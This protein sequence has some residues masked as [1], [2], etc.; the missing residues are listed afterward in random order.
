[1]G[2]NFT[3]IKKEKLKNLE[4]TFD[5]MSNYCRKQ[6]FQYINFLAN[7]DGRFQFLTYFLPRKDAIQAFFKEGSWDKGP[8]WAVFCDYLT[9][10]VIITIKD[11]NSIRG[12]LYIT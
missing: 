2:L 1:M 11:Q 3:L 4:A 12:H 8:H 10:N 5:F 7:D 6:D 9:L